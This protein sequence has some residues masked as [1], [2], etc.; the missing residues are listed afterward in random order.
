MK[1]SPP[2]FFLLLVLVAVCLSLLVSCHSTE[3]VTEYVPVEIDLE[4]LVQPVLDLRPEDVVLIDDPKDLSDIMQNSVSFQ[5][6]Y[7]NWRLYAMSLERVYEE[8]DK[9]LAPSTD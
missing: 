7:E 1:K 5:Y 6:A 2:R 8:L 4:R 3:T 9:V